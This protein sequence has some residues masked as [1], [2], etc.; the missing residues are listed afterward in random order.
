MSG[1]L[2]TSVS[3]VLLALTVIADKLM[4]NDFYESKPKSAW[5]ISSV[6][7]TF[8]GLIS[9]VLVILFSDNTD[10]FIQTVNLITSGHWPLA[11][12]MIL[13][14][15]FVSLT[16][17]SYF[18]CMAADAVSALVAIAISATPVFVF[19]LQFFLFDA[20]WTHIHTLSFF[21]TIAGLI[22]FEAVAEHDE[23][24]DGRFNWPLL[25]VIGFGTAYLL[26]VDYLLPVIE[27]S[28]ETDELTASLAA[29]PFYW[30]GFFIGVFAIFLKET[31]AFVKNIF[32]RWEFLAI[33]LALEV[34]GAG[35]YFF[36]FFGLS[37]ISATLVALIT[38]AHVVLV[39]LFDIY[40]RKQREVAAENQISTTNIFFFRLR[41]DKLDAYAISTKTLSLQG[42][43]IALVILGL[44]IWPY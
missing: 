26:L 41:T 29:M 40:V 38:G 8:F 10:S 14:G 31:R 11:V 17:L 23:A 7:G 22:G 39:W 34:I 3:A 12:G 25:G 16:L 19:A 30:L 15:T 42:V 35:F 27:T 1:L 13:A 43:F 2:I 24:D 18:E 36:E 32:S 6:L 21:L 44:S 28:L 20:T 9:T 4:V 33:V 37:K 5:F